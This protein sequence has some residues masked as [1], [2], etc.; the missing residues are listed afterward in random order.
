MRASWE[1]APKTLCAC[2][3]AECRL[4]QLKV[5]T[6]GAPHRG[7]V[8]AG[9]VSGVLEEVLAMGKA[10]HALQ[11][12]LTWRSVLGDNRAKMRLHSQTCKTSWEVGE[13]V[14]MGVGRLRDLLPEDCERGL[15]P[16]APMPVR[17]L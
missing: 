15:L 13:F 16:T 7:V 17:T 4:R 1:T 12:M 8:A 10:C 11:H 9:R 2:T 5:T 3:P 14:N 6:P